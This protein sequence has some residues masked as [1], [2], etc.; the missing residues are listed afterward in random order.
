[1]FSGELFELSAFEL[2]VKVVPGLGA[3]LRE[4]GH[5]ARLF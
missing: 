5:A 2:V 1:M 3:L 4:Q